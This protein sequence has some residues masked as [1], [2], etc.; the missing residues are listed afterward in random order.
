MQML[1]QKD[2]LVFV[3]EDP[4]EDEK[5]KV[6]SFR[7]SDI[8]SIHFNFP[9]ISFWMKLRNVIVSIAAFLFASADATSVFAREI[10][11]IINLKSGSVVVQHI[12]FVSGKSAKVLKDKLTYHVER[13][14]HRA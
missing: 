13:A 7:W 2:H 10:E 5:T 4:L 6:Q 8:N 1:I 14:S 11:I 3:S 9:E 12:A